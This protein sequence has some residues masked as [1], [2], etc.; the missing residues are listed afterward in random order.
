MDDTRR[1]EL[2]RKIEIHSK[3][4]VQTAREFKRIVVNGTKFRTKNHE[5]GRTTQNNG[6][7][8]C[9]EDGSTWCGI[10]TRLIEMQYYDGSRQILFKY[11]WAN[12]P[13]GRGYKEDNSNFGLVNFSCLIHIG[14]RI[15]DDPFVLSSQV[16]QVFYVFNEKGLNWIVVVKTKLR[17]KYDIDKDDMTNDEY[18]LNEC[19]NPKIDDTIDVATNDVA[20]V[21]NDMEGITI[22]LT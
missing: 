4:L 3:G 16:S 1:N 20:W 2:G 11:D 22:D 10:L 8:V 21:R 6:V 9:T 14:E 12:I 7:S 13:G 17:D 18:I 19:N 5:N 15:T